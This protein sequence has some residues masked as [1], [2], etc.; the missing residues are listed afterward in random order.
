MACMSTRLMSSKSATGV[1]AIQYRRPS[2]HEAGPIR[3]L[4]LKMLENSFPVFSTTAKAEYQRAWELEKLLIRL[5]QTKD[6]LL[7]AWHVD[8]P[9]GLVSGTQGEGG[10]GTIVWLMV[11][12]PYR[13]Q[14]LG[15]GLFWEAVKYYQTLNCHKI[16]LTAPTVEAKNFYLQQGMVVEGFHE[17]HWYGINFWSM[18]YPI[19]A[20]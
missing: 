16:K 20:S 14:R 10:V 8:M 12:A 5:E 7:A 4:F 13:N 11:D 6:L 17:N 15:R 9:V 2:M 3:Q 18:G 19:T 1:D